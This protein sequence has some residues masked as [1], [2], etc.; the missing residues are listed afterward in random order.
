VIRYAKRVLPAVAAGGLL[1]SASGCLALHK[2]AH[3][4]VQVT[5][6]RIVLYK[7][8]DGLERGGETVLKID[9]YA[10]HPVNMILAKTTLSAAQLPPSLLDAVTARDDSR[11]VAMTSRVDKA[12]ITLAYGAIPNPSP[13]VVSLH[14]YL[15]PGKRYLLFDKLGGY[16]HGLAL[17]LNVPRRR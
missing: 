17:V 6:T 15:E 11:I 5:D 3:V 1:L 8:S 9:N 10:Q 14:V 16:K 13:K 4:E 2:A 7:P 12:G